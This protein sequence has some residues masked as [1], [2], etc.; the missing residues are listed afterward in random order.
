MSASLLDRAYRS[1]RG[2]LDR[3]HEIIITALR[4][5]DVE[6]EQ[7]DRYIYTV[8]G[9]MLRPALVLLSGLGVTGSKDHAG[10]LV[11]LAAVF[12]LFHNASL[13][14]DDLI[15]EESVRRNVPTVHAVFGPHIAV[16]AGDVLITRAFALLSSSFPPPI[17]ERVIDVATD[18]CHGEI[19]AA[20][21][22]N[23]S[24]QT[25]VYEEIVRL[26]TARMMGVACETGAMVGGAHAE[27]ARAYSEFGMSFGRAY[28]LVDDLIDKDHVVARSEV[29]GLLEPELA[30]LHEHVSDLPQNLYTGGLRTIVD[31]LLEIGRGLTDERQSATI[32]SRII[33]PSKAADRV[34]HGR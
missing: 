12:E 30:S 15:D 24:I 25:P 31:Y 32:R 7:I 28:Q 33:D 26:K 34:G 18:M 9:K 13:I 16:L 8:P 14:H 20:A 29:V 6:L 23:E 1:I 21:R 3:T 17:V 2:E 5:A 4:N 19:L 10:D 22:K 27:R 11:L